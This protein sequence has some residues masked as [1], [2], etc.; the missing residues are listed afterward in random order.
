MMRMSVD[1]EIEHGGVIAI[2]APD[3]IDS[4][5][6]SNSRYFVDVDPTLRGTGEGHEN[7]I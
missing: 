7:R 3:F 1:V 5:N 4:P 6:S 2:T